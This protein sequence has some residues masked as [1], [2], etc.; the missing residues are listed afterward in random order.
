MDALLNLVIQNITLIAGAV[1][2]L[3]VVGPYLLLQKRGSQ[4]MSKEIER[5]KQYGLSE[6]ATIH[7]KVNRAI[8]IG[9]GS[10]INACPE[11]NV[12][13]IVD[14][15]AEAVYASRCVGHGACARA[16]PVGAIELV[17]GTEKRGVDIP[18]VMPNFESNME[19]I[20][21]AGELGGMGL[22]RNAMTQGMESVGYIEEDLKAGH[23]PKEPGVY[24][25]LI[26]GAGPAGLAASLTAK[27]KNLNYILLDQEEEFGGAI[28]S[29]PRAKVVMTRPVE[30]PI[31]GKIRTGELSKEQL[32]ALW[33]DIIAKAQ[34]EVNGNEKVLSLTRDTTKFI[35]KTSK[36][37]LLTRFVL[38]AIGR[39][40]TPRKL[41]VPGE[42]LPKVMYRLL[43]PEHY[44]GQKILVV[45]GGDSAVEA[46]VALAKQEGNEV[47]LS[48]RGPTFSRIKAGNQTRI[49]AAV[50]AGKV[51][52]MMESNVREIKANA[53]TL[54]QKGQTAAIPNDSVF[55][56]AGGILPNDFLK[57]CG[58]AI[59]TKFGTR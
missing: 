43:E 6:P 3:A 49:D 58:I 27:S 1:I 41:G 7:P 45:G 52:L 25:L 39:R 31:Y 4:K 5:A 2:I 54:E 9:S 34:L 37:E 15:K 47:T 57:E 35:V 22:I 8:C 30:V 50:K 26:V 51:T 46:A 18:Q 44:N 23:F 12:L 53:V 32:L 13:G 56:F 24:D 17:F 20:F 19:H 29:Y 16:C 48:Y 59:E 55:I 14:N 42:K 28:L 10:C 36:R 38:L 33:K 21:I 11:K 40:G